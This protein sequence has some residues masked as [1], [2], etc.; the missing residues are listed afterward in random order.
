MK[1]AKKLRL[2]SR[3]ICMPDKESLSQLISLGAEQ[4]WMQAGLDELAKTPLSHWQ[5]EYTR[6]FVN[7]LPNSAAPPFESV[8]RHQTL[9]GPVVDELHELYQ[10]AGLAIGE[11]P[12]DYLGTQLEFA[13]HLADSDDPRAAD[14][15]ARLWQDHLQH[16]LPRFITDLCQQSRLLIYRL[17]GGQLTLLLT[18]QQ[19]MLC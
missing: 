15:Q 6:L 3:M 1:D 13:A 4:P 19:N 9:F 17:W 10:D 14:W 12:A 11:M 18:Q 7:G 5:G 8:Y 16:W 2:L